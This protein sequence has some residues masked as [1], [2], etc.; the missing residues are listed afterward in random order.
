[1]NERKELEDQLVLFLRSKEE[2][3]H[4]VTDQL[5][6]SSEKGFEIYNNLKYYKF[7]ATSCPT[8]D[9]EVWDHNH[10]LTTSPTYRRWYGELGRG[11]KCLVRTFNGK[12][13]LMSEWIMSLLEMD[14]VVWERTPHLSRID[15]R[16]M[17]VSRGDT[18]SRWCYIGNNL[19]RVA[20]NH[21]YTA[22]RWNHKD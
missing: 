12:K 13:V 3:K 20:L 5:I 21:S 4:L 16:F 1:M 11:K 19:A 2:F 9:I 18:K 22:N 15:N 17:R 6:K 7:H 14:A 10:L 8:N